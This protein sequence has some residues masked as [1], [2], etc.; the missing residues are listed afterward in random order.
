MTQGSFIFLDISER[1]LL[2][3]QL[4]HIPSRP[5]VHLRPSLLPSGFFLWLGADIYKDQNL[6]KKETKSSKKP[7]QWVNFFEGG[8]MCGF[9]FVASNIFSDLHNLVLDASE[10]AWLSQDP[11]PVGLS[12]SRLHF[13]SGPRT[14]P[15]ECHGAGGLA[16]AFT[17]SFMCPLEDFSD[18]EAGL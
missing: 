4:S 16:V 2:I 18:I 13:P 14:L 11:W 10:F 8:C 12:F 6:L 7:L 15:C 17:T 3:T 9:I 1:W 5:Q